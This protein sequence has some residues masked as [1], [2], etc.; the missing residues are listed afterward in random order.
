MS[1]F[2]M[3][4]KKPKKQELITVILQGGKEEHGL[5]ILYNTKTK[6]MIVIMDG[7]AAYNLSS[8]SNNLDDPSFHIATIVYRFTAEQYTPQ[9][10]TNKSAKISANQNFASR[11]ATNF[12][13][14]T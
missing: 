10:N 13:G 11:I 7:Y 14:G 5:K 9:A 2:Y 8:Q 3:L 1:L 12:T 6:I 4:K